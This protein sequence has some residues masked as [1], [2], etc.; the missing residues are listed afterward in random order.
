MTTAWLIELD[1]K[2]AGVQALYWYVSKSGM[3][4]WTSLADDALKFDTEVLAW[5]STAHWATREGIV[6]REHAWAD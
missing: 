2:P 1:P 4:G 3:F 6:V 5:L